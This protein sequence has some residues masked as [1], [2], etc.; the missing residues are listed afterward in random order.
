MPCQHHFLLTAGLQVG[1]LNIQTLIFCWS[2]AFLLHH[3]TLE[4]CYRYDKLQL[5]ATKQFCILSV[6]IQSQEAFC[7]CS[8]NYHCKRQ[9]IKQ[10]LSSSYR[11]IWLQ[12]CTSPCQRKSHLQFRPALAGNLST[13][14]CQCGLQSYDVASW[15]EEEVV[16]PKAEAVDP[17]AYSQALP[18]NRS[19]FALQAGCEQD[20][21]TS[22]RD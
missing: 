12:Y 10:A 22:E 7:A 2:Y 16:N 15:V 17:G 20:Q 11:F 5:E 1:H 8:F 21:D 14:S 18:G 3:L 19:A 4:A 6:G 9:Q 13:R